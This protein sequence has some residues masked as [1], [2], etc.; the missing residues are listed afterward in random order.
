MNIVIILVN[1]PKLTVLSLQAGDTINNPILVLAKI[2]QQADKILQLK[3]IY[4]TP[5]LR[6]INSKPKETPVTN[7][8][9]SNIIL[10]Q[11][12]EVPPKPMKVSQNITKHII[13]DAIHTTALPKNSRFHNTPT[14]TY[15]L[16]SQPN[17]I[18]NIYENFTEKN[19]AQYIFN[20]N[21]YIHHIY[22]EDRKKETIDSLLVEANK[23]I[24]FRSLSNE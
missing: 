1:L 16:R 10:Y 23:H 18:Q 24:W 14:Y 12:D 5:L 3:E 6:V 13:V 8:Q 22:T 4:N 7:S 15:N 19:I 2:L 17:I 9:S 20:P 21:N 11:D